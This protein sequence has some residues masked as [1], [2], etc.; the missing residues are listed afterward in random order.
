MEKMASTDK[1]KI[2]PCAGIIVF[3]GDR[4]IL[5]ETERGNLSFPK[6][7]REKGES[8]IET[9]W[10]ELKEETGLTFDLVTLLPNVHIDEY[11][12]KGNLSIRYFLGR[13][14]N[15]SDHTFT[16]DPKELAQ[17]KWYP[18]PEA[19]SLSQLK[20]TRKEILRQAYQIV[21]S[22]QLA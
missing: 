5:V 3:D 16:F 9:A 13:I 18:I 10:R 21:S 19:L 22:H 12:D 6:G 4:T 11:S 15:S 20:S 2:P 7:K 1:D 14:L 17:V 8:T